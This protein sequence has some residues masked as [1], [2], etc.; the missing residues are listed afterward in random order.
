MYAGGTTIMTTKLL[1]LAL[2]AGGSMFAQTRFS[3]GITGGGSN[4]GYQPQAAPYANAQART[5]YQAQPYYQQPSYNNRYDN[6]YA[7]QS[8]PQTNNGYSQQA[9]VRS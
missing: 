9:Y 7:N 6:S 2:L 4:R 1:A 8:Y 5:S 3:F